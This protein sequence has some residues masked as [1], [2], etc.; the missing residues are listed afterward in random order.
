MTVNLEAQYD[1]NAKSIAREVHGLLQVDSASQK[2]SAI[3]IA[4][5]SGNKS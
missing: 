4:V 5:T 2:R 1:G 3:H